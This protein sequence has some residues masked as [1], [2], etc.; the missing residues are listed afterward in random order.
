FQDAYIVNPSEYVRWAREQLPVFY[1]P[2]L[3]YWVVTRYAAIKDIFRDPVTFSPSNV[4]EPVAAPAPE[5]AEIL[6]QYDYNMSRTLVNEDEP[7]HMARRRVLMAPF[8]PEHLR[9]HEP[10]VRQLVTEAID[11]FIDDGEAD[12]VRQLFW[13][14]P[15]SVALNFRGIDDE[16][17]REEMHKFAI[18]HTI[19]A[20]GR[21]TPEQRIEIAHPVGKFWQF[22]GQVLEKMR[23]TP[24]GPGW[25]RYSIRQQQKYPD[26]VTDS[27]LH[28]MMMAI[29]VAA[30]ET[31]T[32]ATA[33]AA[34][35]LL[36][37]R[38]AWDE[39]CQNPEL[40]SPAVEEC[41][42]HVGSIASWRRRTT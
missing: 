30:H 22:S 32:F 5:V 18:A 38:K 31:T 25:M 37:N 35:F 33:N 41:L 9:D 15:F 26:V 11:S 4:L 24:D 3:D 23:Q 10:M 14:V 2:E 8:T 19:Y 6:K 16:R 40:I 7:M 17:D 39:I 21:P 42:R 1:S 28:S 13:D 34:K 20:F 29:I 27:Y 36:E 12:L